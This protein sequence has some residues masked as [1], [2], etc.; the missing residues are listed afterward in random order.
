[1]SNL[2]TFS[3][4]G[5][6]TS[7]GKSARHLDQNISFHKHVAKVCAFCHYLIK[8]LCYICRHLTCDSAYDLACALVASRH[9]T[10]VQHGRR[11]NDRLQGVQDTLAHTVTRSS[12]FS[13]ALWLLQSLHWLP[14][15][16]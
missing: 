15:K 11:D 8:Y 5:V 10:L 9:C 4:G 3:G 6:G 2:G 12:P 1:M 13:H 14:L 16:F 7:P